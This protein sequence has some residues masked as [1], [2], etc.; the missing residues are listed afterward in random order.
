MRADLSVNGSPGS[1][2]ESGVQG[3]QHANVDMAG[4]SDSVTPAR[5]ATLQAENHQLQAELELV[6]TDRNRLLDIQRRLMEV[7][8]TNSPDRLVHDVRNVLNERELFKALADA[9][10]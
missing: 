10:A 9:Q 3:M 2:A 6:K 4:F 5:L 7:L 8:G 1:P